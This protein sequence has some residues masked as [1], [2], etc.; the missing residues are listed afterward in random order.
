MRLELS[1]IKEAENIP[2]E[3]KLLLNLEPRVLDWSK[4]R[5]KIMNIQDDNI[6]VYSE[7]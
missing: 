2:Q 4:E 7:R 5:R 6:S 3:S 1:N